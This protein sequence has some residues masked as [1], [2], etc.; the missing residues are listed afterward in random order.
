MDGAA[1]PMAGSRTT[2]Y[3]AAVRV[4]FRHNLGIHA[5]DPVAGTVETDELEVPLGGSTDKAFVRL[6]VLA[7]DDSIVVHVPNC[8]IGERWLKN[9][10][11]DPGKV[12]PEVER[13][14]SAVLRDLAAES[15]QETGRSA[16]RQ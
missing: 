5:R 8:W 3:A 7:T 16:P 15:A 6:R 10:D 1:I 9:Y 4:L 2:N 14:Y 12:P 13:I 11:C